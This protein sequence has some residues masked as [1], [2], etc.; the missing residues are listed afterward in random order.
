MMVL[1]TPKFSTLLLNYVILFLELVSGFISSCNSHSI[2]LRIQ[3][4]GLEGCYVSTTVL[5]TNTLLADLHRL[6]R[7]VKRYAETSGVCLPARQC[8]PG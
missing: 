7:P 5:L 6:G 2:L 8:G 1:L 4:Q 3:L